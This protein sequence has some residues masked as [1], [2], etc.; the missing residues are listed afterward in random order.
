[1][2]DST[3]KLPALDPQTVKPLVGSDY[4]PPHDK[5]PAKRERRRIGDAVGLKNFGVNLMRLPPGCASSQRHWHT[6][7]DEFV[8]VVEG[9]VV[10]VS[11]GGEQT[12]RAG[13]AAGFPAGTGD[14][15]HLI[16][17]TSKDAVLLEVGDR[18]AADEVD[19]SDIDMMVRWVN[20][21]ERYL[22]KDGKP[23]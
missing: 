5:G 15:H 19:Y 21:E 13:M 22:H 23:Y 1:M 7:Q 6:K 18:T 17:R 12:L 9:E 11:D 20:G 3:L 14:G 2:N 4:P 10:L 8:F 16:N